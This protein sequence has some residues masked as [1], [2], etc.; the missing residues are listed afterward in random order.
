MEVHLGLSQQTNGGRDKVGG[1]VVMTMVFYTVV[2][3]ADE[4]FR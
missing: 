2:Q 4:R 1:G 3:A